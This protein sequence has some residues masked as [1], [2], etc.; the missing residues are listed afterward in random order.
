MATPRPLSPHAHP[1]RR[2]ER[3]DVLLPALALLLA[4]VVR[5]VLMQANAGITMDS[6]LYVRMSEWLRSAHHEGSPA[7]HGYPLW[8]ALASYVI[9]GRELP[10]RLVSLAASLAF[11]ACVW[12]VSRRRLSPGRAFV[13]ALIVALHPLLA[14][15][16]VAL[17]TEA[18]FLA[19]AF[20]A[21]TLLD[22]GRLRLGG[23]LLGA[24]WWVR[25]EAAVIAPL[26]LLMSRGSWRERALSLLIAGCVALPYTAFLRVEQGYWSLTPKTAL[27]RAPFADGR[28]AEWRLH[29]ASAFADSVSLTDR[30][31]RDG[32]A[33]LR[34]YPH[35]LWDQVRRLNESWN[36]V[37][38]TGSM[39]GLLLAAG[40]GPWLAFLV[41][42]LVY[43]LLSAPA[44]LRFAQLVIPGLVVPFAAMLS[45]ARA[46]TPGMPLA[47]AVGLAV[48]LGLLWS[49]VSGKLALAF[50]DGPMPA[51]RG[52][53]AWLAAHSAPD[54]VIMDRKSYVPFFA[55]RRH[56]QLPDESLDALL[57][58]ARAS[59]ATHLVVEEYVV[60]ALRPQLA[61]LLDTGHMAGERR[62]RLVFAVRP[63]PGDGVAVFE[64]VR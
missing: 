26:A 60:R 41:L 33:I 44:D 6:A 19:L 61:P 3:L 39:I 55:E 37:L 27:V 46:R 8:I 5:L 56:V 52:A 23:A 31:A 38:L 9:P 59:G 58:Y 14:V 25:P 4:L 30:L 24:A 54:A 57:D 49:G 36:F 62:A 15:Y 34:G 45:H 64:I 22:G 28:A 40:R 35:R 16:G 29:D 18:T 63:A 21:V 1:D 11:V 53:G 48:A 7:H 47:L 20:G 17:M 10:G 51:L 43:P 32:G 12:V 42:P 50:D 2:A 13:P